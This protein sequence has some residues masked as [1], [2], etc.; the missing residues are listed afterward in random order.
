MSEATILQRR[1]VHT[2]RVFELAVESVRLPNGVAVDLDVL[3]HPG[4]AAILPLTDAG[5]VLLIRQ[6]RHAAGGEIWEIPAGTLNR[7]EKPFDCAHRELEE[8]VG[9]RAA[10]LVELGEIVPVPGYSTERIHLYLARSLTASKQGLDADEL[11]S[12]V[13]AVPAVEAVRWVVDGTIVD[14]KSAVAIC[15]AR[16][17]GLLTGVPAP[18]GRS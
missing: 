5:E 14:A 3:R 2:G 6:F 12:E 10:E 18:G 13:R 1:V 8:E 17:R 7:G 16:E 9:M 15:R 11:I 4:A